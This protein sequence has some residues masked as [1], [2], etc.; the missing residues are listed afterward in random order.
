[1]SANICGG[2]KFNESIEQ[3]GCGKLIES[4]R[5]KT[6]WRMRPVA[7]SNAVAMVYYCRSCLMEFPEWKAISS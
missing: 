1:M 3:D 6:A 4:P 2:N 5:A 7:K